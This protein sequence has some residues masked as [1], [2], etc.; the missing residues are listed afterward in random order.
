VTDPPAELLVIQPLKDFTCAT[1]GNPDDLLTM[2]NGEALCMTCADLAH[3]VFLPSGD[4]ALT[5]RAKKLS[6]LSAVVIR[7]SRTRKRYERQGILV[8]PEALALAEEQ[9]LADS[10]V[11]LRRQARDKERRAQQD[12]VF[13]EQ[14]AAEILRL[15]PAC[16]PERAQ[17]IAEHAAVRGSGR[18]G[19]SAAARAFD[20]GAVTAAVVASVR[21]IDTSYDELLMS[22]VP[23]LD[24]RDRVRVAID[25]VLAAWRRC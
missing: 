19:R 9:C 1:C 5:R 8:E 3:L 6:T 21:H 16:P 23:R 7:F 12:V 11:R 22:G 17:A 18:V 15:F 4:A 20:E 13:Q 10:E 14:F 25:E 2:E 24:A